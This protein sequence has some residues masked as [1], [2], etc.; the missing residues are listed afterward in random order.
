MRRSD[1]TAVATL[2][3]NE[4]AMTKPKTEHLLEDSSLPDLARF[5]TLREE[6]PDSKM[7]LIRRAWPHIVAA[8]AGC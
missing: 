7:A 6:K 3:L 8:L 5:R 4:T 2:T 1:S